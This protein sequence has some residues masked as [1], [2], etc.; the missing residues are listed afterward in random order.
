MATT[1]QLAAVELRKI[2]ERIEYHQKSLAELY[3][4]RR[5]RARW[6]EG[7]H[8]AEAW[9]CMCGVNQVDVENGEDTCATCRGA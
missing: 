3:A 8:C 2:N 6:T 5:G 1:E 7:G 9:C 4:S